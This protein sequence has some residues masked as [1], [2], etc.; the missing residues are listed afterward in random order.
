MSTVYL[1]HFK[2]CCCWLFP[3]ALVVWWIVYNVSRVNDHYCNESY[4]NRYLGFNKQYLKT[5]ASES[6][7]SANHNSE[8]K[9]WAVIRTEINVNG[10]ATQHWE[11]DEIRRNK[12]L[13]IFNG[14]THSSNYQRSM[15]KS[16]WEYINKRNTGL[17][18]QL[19]VTLST[20]S[21]RE[22]KQETHEN[23]IQDSNTQRVQPCSYRCVFS[24]PDVTVTYKHSHSD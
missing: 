12:M 23:T 13:N 5:D 15:I 18:Q 22:M 10:K 6:L 17:D 1:W 11:V 24:H 21:S 9:K 8:R 2:Y 3:V 20:Y 4:C 19:K 14:V 16:M 7:Y